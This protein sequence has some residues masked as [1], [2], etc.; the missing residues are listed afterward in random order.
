MEAQGN[1]KEANKCLDVPNTVHEKSTCS[2]GVYE[3]EIEEVGRIK[4]GS[5]KGKQQQSGAGVVD[6][7][8]VSI[9]RCL[10]CMSV[11]K[12]L[13]FESR[14]SLKPASFDPA[15]LPVTWGGQNEQAAFTE[16][17]HDSRKG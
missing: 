1:W 12:N 7:N 3:A 13:K 9:L 14:R 5:W 4:R 11:H 6:V 10:H 16:T 17:P 8:W 2:K 15:C